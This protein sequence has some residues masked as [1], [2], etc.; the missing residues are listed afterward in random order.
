MRSSFQNDR[1]RELLNQ[2]MKQYQSKPLAIEGATPGYA[3]TW[4]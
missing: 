4:M 3:P 1:W 2:T